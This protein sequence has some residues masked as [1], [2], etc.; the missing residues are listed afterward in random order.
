MHV[1]WYKDH[2]LKHEILPNRANTGMNNSVGGYAH[3]AMPDSPKKFTV[4]LRIMGSGNN[5]NIASL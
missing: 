3:C 1:I 2:T 5:Q 4:P